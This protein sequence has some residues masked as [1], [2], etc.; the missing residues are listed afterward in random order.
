MHTLQEI[1]FLLWMD[2]ILLR[3]ATESG[4]FSRFL[5]AFAW[6]TWMCTPHVLIFFRRRCAFCCCC[7]CCWCFLKAKSSCQQFISFSFFFVRY[8][9]KTSIT[10]LYSI[11]FQVIFQINR[12]SFSH[13]GDHCDTRKTIQTWEIHE[14]CAMQG[15]AKMPSRKMKR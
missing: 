13:G 11:S 10:W 1:I 4:C 2:M 12:F 14:K 6:L 7:C 15:V 8:I 5:L 9:M 3:D